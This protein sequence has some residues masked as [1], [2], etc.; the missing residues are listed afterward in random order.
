MNETLRSFFE[1]RDEKESSSQKKLEDSLSQAAM[2][3]D[4][5]AV[6]ELMLESLEDTKLVPNPRK[7]AKQ[8]GKIL[9]L[10]TDRQFNP[11]ATTDQFPGIPGLSRLRDFLHN[12][13]N[14]KDAEANR[15]ALRDGLRS[16]NLLP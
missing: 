16:L 3:F 2:V 9:F 7:F 8:V 15:E 5:I 12:F 6:Q 10:M 1:K 11:T 4:P 14:M 13:E